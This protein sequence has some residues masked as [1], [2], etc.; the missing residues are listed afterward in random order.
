MVTADRVEVVA[1]PRMAELEI[2]G[3]VSS[4]SD[5]VE[6][7]KSR[8]KAAMV[9]TPKL[10]PE[11]FAT[12]AEVCFQG[13]SWPLVIHRSTLK[14]TRVEFSEGFTIRVPDGAARTEEGPLREALCKWLKARLLREAHKIAEVHAPAFG[15]HPRT[16]RLREQKT[17]WGSCGIH[18]DIQLNWRL[19]FAPLSVLEYVVVHELCHIRHRD[20]SARFWDLVRTHLPGYRQERVWLRNHGAGLMREL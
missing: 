18:N 4:N 8:L 6:K 14:K 16:I 2:H 19:V 3:F 15:L 7:T 17:R 12:G 13:H 5:W 9:A 20:H 1:P 11:Q 10:L